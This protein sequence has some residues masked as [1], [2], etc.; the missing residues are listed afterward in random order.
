MLGSGRLNTP[1][2]CHTT[3]LKQLDEDKATGPDLL[4]AK[5]LKKCAKELGTPVAK[6]TRRV[7]NSGEWPEGWRVH[8]ILPLYKKKSVWDPKNYRGVHL[9]AQLSKVV[10][11]LLGSLFFAFLATNRSFWRK[12]VRLHEKGGLQR[13]TGTKHSRVGVGA[14]L[15]TENS[16]VLFRC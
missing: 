5:V 14:S 12:P 1:P 2:T 7:L 6:L 8:W 9:T 3:L 15:G 16:T 11:R 4:S 10:E 13:L